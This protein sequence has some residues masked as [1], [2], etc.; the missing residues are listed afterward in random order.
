MMRRKTCALSI[1][2]RPARIPAGRENRSGPG[3]AAT[4][5]ESGFPARKASCF[6][7]VGA[8]GEGSGEKKA[9]DEI[10]VCRLVLPN[11]PKGIKPAMFCNGRGKKSSLPDTII[12]SSLPTEEGGF[13][14]QQK[15]FFFIALLPEKRL[16]RSAS[17]K[18]TE[19]DPCILFLERL[20]AQH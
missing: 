7:A 8:A 11:Q 6:S 13:K 5:C 20:S 17:Q 10:G 1:A 3:I 15:R 19:S 18:G 2:E 12:L 4:H 9:A 14:L 16:G